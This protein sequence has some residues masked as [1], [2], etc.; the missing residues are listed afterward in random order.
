MIGAQAVLPEHADVANAIGAITSDVVIE[1]RLRI[2]PGDGSGFLIEGLTGARRFK[3]IEA[4]DAFA[5]QALVDM[6]RA[7]AREAGTST[8][9]VMIQSEDQLPQDAAGRP[10]FIGRILSA[11]LSGPPDRVVSAAPSAMVQR[12]LETC[13]QIRQ[14]AVDDTAKHQL[15]DLER[16]A[17]DFSSLPENMSNPRRRRSPGPDESQLMHGLFDLRAQLLKAR[18][19]MH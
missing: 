17:Q 5:K 12:I 2:I 15:E 11:H 6:V 1:R 13:R 7:L 9:T 16:A 3:E 19:S 18:G 4:A 8:Q 10:I 14:K